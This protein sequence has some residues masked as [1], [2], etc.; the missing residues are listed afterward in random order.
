LN[1]TEINR[2][3]LVGGSPSNDTFTVANL[4]ADTLNYQ[5]SDNA[6]WLSVSPTSGSSSGEADP[7]TVSYQ[8][9]SLPPGVHHALITI[10][11]AGAFNSPQTLLVELT[12]DGPTI[13]LNPTSIQRTMIV[14]SEPAAG[15]FTVANGG[16]NVLN[17]SVSEQSGWLSVSPESGS[18]VGE[19]DP[20]T[21]HF[22][23]AGLSLGEYT[24]S[25][26]V[27]SA[28]AGNSP[29]VVS[30]TL[31]VAMSTADFD[32]DGD[33]DQADFGHLQGCLTGAGITQSTPAC[34]DARL[35]G[36]EDVDAADFA[37]FA[38]C[39][40]GAGRHPDPACTA[41]P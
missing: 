21:V 8:S 1:K 15:M 24:A 38:S 6:N 27:T 14:G 41:V 5:I 9:A 20:I 35:D 37:I 26:T 18:S 16:P 22:N 3:V 39:L 12:V 29:Q 30:V 33:V 11:A 28:D 25:I 23:A 13:A 4:G 40:G 2:G 17:Y 36:D 34:F 7:I 31:T 32:Q 10:S 19:A